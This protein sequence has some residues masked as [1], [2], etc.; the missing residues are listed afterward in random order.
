M[1]RIGEKRRLENLV[2]ENTPLYAP[3]IAY[4]GL[5]LM[6]CG[7]LLLEHYARASGITPLKIK[8]VT[9]PVELVSRQ[10]K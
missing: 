7:A 2:S 10:A 8:L 9:E 3:V 6:R 1:R 5:L 4:I